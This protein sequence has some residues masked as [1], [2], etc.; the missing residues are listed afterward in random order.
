LDQVFTGVESRGRPHLPL[1]ETRLVDASHADD[2]R[3][4]T[5]PPP[6]IAS[7]FEVINYRALVVKFDSA[8]L[9]IELVQSPRFG[10]IFRAICQTGIQA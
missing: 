10:E 9:S 5:P 3:Q 4:T 6:P 1:A 8:A 2:L 7:A